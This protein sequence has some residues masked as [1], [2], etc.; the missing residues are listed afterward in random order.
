VAPYSI[1]GKHETSQE[2]TPGNCL[3]HLFGCALTTAGWLE[4]VGEP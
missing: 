2:E 1:E 3:M 4:A